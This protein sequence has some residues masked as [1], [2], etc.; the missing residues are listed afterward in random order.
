MIE[1]SQ[2][3][4]DQD[5]FSGS[6]RSYPNEHDR[7]TWVG[8]GEQGLQHALD[9]RDCVGLI[10]KP[11]VL[12]RLKDLPARCWTETKNGSQ[13]CQWYTKALFG[14][15]ALEVMLDSGA[16]LNTIPC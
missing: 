5:Q 9:Q 15:I 1:C 12:N 10:K 13:G 6:V 3:D 2:R 4:L 14:P 11:R 7:R 16:G 8:A